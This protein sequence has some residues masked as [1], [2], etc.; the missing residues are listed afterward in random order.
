MNHVEGWAILTEAGKPSV[1]TVAR[2][3]KD[4]VSRLLANDILD[5]YSTRG[6]KIVAGNKKRYRAAKEDAK[7]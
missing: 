7:G 2:D 1:N 4:A 3:A 6:R 5:P